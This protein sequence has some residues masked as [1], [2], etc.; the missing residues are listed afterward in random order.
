MAELDKG[1]RRGFRPA[2]PR[3]AFALA[4]N[5]LTVSMDPTYDTHDLPA[6]PRA[7]PVVRLDTPS[8]PFFA[9]GDLDDDRL[10]IGNARARTAIVAFV[11]GACGALA[12]VAA[13]LALG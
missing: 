7:L 11:T 4:L 5:T 1:G 6:V 13:V 8:E 9:A 3:R 2:P 10:P 12:F